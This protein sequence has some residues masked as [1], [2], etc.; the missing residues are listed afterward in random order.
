[1]R[2]KF[3]GVVGSLVFLSIDL[4][5][6]DAAALA[7][8]PSA[9]ASKTIVDNTLPE[10]MFEAAYQ[11]AS[12]SFKESTDKLPQHDTLKASAIPLLGSFLN[13]TALDSS[14]THSY[15]Q[16]NAAALALSHYIAEQL[17]MFISQGVAQV[18]L[19]R[20][21]I[22]VQKKAEIAAL[23]AGI[24]GLSE[25]P[26]VTLIDLDGF[27]QV[28][29]SRGI[30]NAAHCKMAQAKKCRT[31]DGFKRFA[32]EC[33]PGTIRNCIKAFLNS[34]NEKKDFVQSLV[35]IEDLKK[36][37]QSGPGLLCSREEIKD[38]GNVEK[39]VDK[40]VEGQYRLRL[41]EKSKK[42]SLKKDVKSL[43]ERQKEVLKKFEEEQKRELAKFKKKQQE[44]VVLYNLFYN[45]EA[46]KKMQ[47]KILD[48][49]AKQRRLGE[50]EKKTLEKYKVWEKAILDQKNL[51]VRVWWGKD[52]NTIPLPP[53]LEVKKDDEQ[54]LEMCKPDILSAASKVLQLKRNSRDLD[55]TS[56]LW[57]VAGKVK[58]KTAV[59]DCTKDENMAKLLYTIDSLGVCN[60]GSDSKPQGE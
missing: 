9:V 16:I 1:M 10:K 48:M 8:P 58:T 45:W 6:E 50:K 54:V 56:C 24:G 23:I 34:N 38:T 12:E 19:Q 44:E 29:R 53:I 57:S 31:L 11:A 14:K 20:K 4:W 22:E 2:T 41:W 32:Q 51:A 55:A 35:K 40:Y 60:I 37:T 47:K 13:I 36:C 42:S 3:Y 17:Y 21:K 30:F 18:Q 7:V 25:K 43:K 49:Q 52:Q 27:L 46:F 39:T 15:A 33:D 59:G 26:P 5:A 28:G